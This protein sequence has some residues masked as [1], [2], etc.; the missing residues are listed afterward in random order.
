LSEEEK[1]DAENK[2]AELIADYRK[3]FPSGPPRSFNEENT[4]AWIDDLFRALGW[5]IRNDIVKEESTGK[6]KRVDYS[7]KIDGTTQFLLEAK[8]ASESLDDHVKQAVQYGYQKSKRWVVL[9]NFEEIRVYNSEYWDQPEEVKRLFL[10]LKLSELADRFDDLWV[11]SKSGF[12]ERLIEQVAKKY[13][14]TKPK[15]PIT[16]LL[17]DDLARWRTLLTTNVNEHKRLN[18]LPADPKAAEEWIDEAVQ[19]ILDRLLFI[20]VAEDKG[21]EEPIL[22]QVLKDWEANKKKPLIAYLKSAF[23]KMDDTYNSGLFREHSSEDLAIDNDV[24]EQVLRETYKSPSGLPYDFGAIDADILGSV[25]EQYLSVLIRKTPKRASLKKDEAHRKEQGIYYTPTYI[26]DYIVRNTLGEMLKGKKPEEVDKIKVLDMACGSGSFLLKSFDVLDEYYKQKD[27]DYAQAKLDAQSEDA[28]ITR[29]TKILKNNIYGVD[30]DPKAVEIAQL[31]LLLKAAERKH[32]LPD[33]RENVKCGNSLID[34]PN[35][36]GERAFDWK[37]EFEGIMNEGG[38]DVIVGNPPYV[39][40]REKIDAKEK[41]YYNERYET[42]RYQVNTYTLFIEKAIKLLKKDGTLGF[43]VPDAWLRVESLSE[44]RRYILQ[45]T[46]LRRIILIRG[47]TFEDAGVESS[48]FVLKNTLDKESTFASTVFPTAEYFECKQDDWLGNQ[49]FEIDLFGDSGVKKLLNK[50]EAGSQRLDDQCLIK[51]GLQAYENGKGTP[52]QSAKDV[53]NRPYDYKH[54]YD[55]DTYKYL[56]G[57]DIGRYFFEWHGQWL[58]YGE[59][60]A[61]PRTLELF[62]ASRILVREIPAKPPHGMVATYAE[63]V[64]L[65]NRSI[66]NILEKNEELN[67]KYVLSVLNSKLMTFYHLN[68]SVKAQRDLFPKITLNDL[69]KFPL[70]IVDAEKQRPLIELSEKML[71]LSK[72]LTEI[73]NKQTDERFK[74]EKEIAETDKKIDELVYDLYG[75]TAEERK[76]VEEAVR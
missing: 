17:A 69:R 74:L 14:K 59:W 7:F 28:K 1:S 44:L 43:I 72:N 48:I 20:R 22:E 23:R 2:I 53:I 73:D 39:F 12:R 9:T 64:Y 55:V 32:R 38:F 30:L 58:R 47:K 19:R 16:R 54:K 52:I 65:N 15:E 18:Q 35:V 76:I 70:K 31:N 40:A 66:I 26:V 62:T 29:K 41:Q 61:A 51:A 5:N 6:R 24:L 10:P 37:K 75:L 11:L 33:L 25:Y 60:L 3:Q 27:K 42:I 56:E 50:I 21:V 67:L 68:K 36:A 63:K 49:N 45:H 71:T 34:D 46:N 8:K 57:K 13:G 4:K